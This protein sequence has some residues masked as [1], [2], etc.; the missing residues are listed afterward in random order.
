MHWTAKSGPVTPQALKPLP[1]AAVLYNLNPDDRP[2]LSIVSY[3]AAPNSGIEGLIEAAHM[4][5][6]IALGERASF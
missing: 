2:E 3:S 1:M 6:S 5:L 4:G